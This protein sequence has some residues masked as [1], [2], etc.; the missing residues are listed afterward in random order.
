MTT[1]VRCLECQFKGT[2]VIPTHAGLYRFCFCQY[3]ITHLRI[4]DAEVERR[5]DNF[6][7]V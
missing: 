4:V 6:Q 3:D 1:E 2:D 7:P 5:C